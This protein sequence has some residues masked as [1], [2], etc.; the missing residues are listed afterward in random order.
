MTITRF[1][2]RIG[3]TDRQRPSLKYAN[4]KGECSRVGCSNQLRRAPDG[5]YGRFCN[6]CTRLL[7]EHG[8]FNTT[9]PKL[10]DEPIA[11][12]YRTIKD[13]MLEMVREPQLEAAGHAWAIQRCETYADHEG[14]GDPLLAQRNDTWLYHHYIHHK[15]RNLEQRPVDVMLHLVGVVGVTQLASEQFA[16][17]DQVDLFLVKRGLGHGLPSIR[18]T[19]D[20]KAAP[21][22]RWSLRKARMLARKM[23][24]DWSLG[25]RAQGLVAGEMLKKMRLHQS[26]A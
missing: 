17:P 14:M 11:M 21:H 16:S 13:V 3:R 26:S 20:G 7:V 1:P 15:L 24:G 6:P 18:L 4:P 19:K 25:P 8:D 23:R 22:G 10:A 12:S 2:P 5:W 9:V